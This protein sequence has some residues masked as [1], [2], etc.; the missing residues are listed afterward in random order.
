MQIFASE[1]CANEHSYSQA[2][3]PYTKKFY[4]GINTSII[5]A[6]IGAQTNVYFFTNQ[7]LNPETVNK[8]NFRVYDENNQLME[9]YLDVMLYHFFYSIKA[10]RGKIKLFLKVEKRYLCFIWLL[11]DRWHVFEFKGT[12]ELESQKYHLTYGHNPI[13]IERNIIVK[14]MV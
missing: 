11:F 1:P 8:D 12:D 5:Y 2:I 13:F 10:I 4:E 7:F 6:Y 14:M 9:S 3:D